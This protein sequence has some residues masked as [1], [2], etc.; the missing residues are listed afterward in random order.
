MISLHEDKIIIDIY[1]QPGAK[2]TSA[3]KTHDNKPKIK[4]AAEPTEGK[5][6]KEVI[7]FFAKLLKLTQKQIEIISGDKSR[8][9]RLAI[10][11]TSTAT[12]EILQGLYI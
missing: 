6:N 5:A 2:V 8:N 10:F 12:Q 4:I 7:K 9:K 3:H 1:V 11:D